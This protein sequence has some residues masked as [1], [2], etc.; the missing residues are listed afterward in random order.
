MDKPSVRQIDSW[1]VA[2]QN[3]RDWMRYWGYRDARLTPPG[4]DAGI[5]VRSSKALAQVKYEARDV[6]RP[7]LQMLVGARGRMHHTDLLFFTGAGYSSQAIDYAAEMGIALF[8][9][10]LDGSMTPASPAARAIVGRVLAAAGSAQEASATDVRKVSGDGDPR[11][12]PEDELSDGAVALIL[13]CLAVLLFILGYG[14]FN[15]VW[16][17][18]IV[19]KFL[20]FGAAFFAAYGL[21]LHAKS[22]GRKRSGSDLAQPAENDEG[23]SK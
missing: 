3:A 17:L 20:A 16:P 2:E 1:H 19:T 13:L 6:G 10:T 5:D 22:K 14:P 12:K 23:Q 15:D 8:K 7:Q 11:Q 18:G 9:Y 4:V 21:R